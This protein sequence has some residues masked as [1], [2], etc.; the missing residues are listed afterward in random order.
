MTSI[1]A[2]IGDVLQR[3]GRVSLRLGDPPTPVPEPFATMLTTL[4]ANRANVNTAANPNSDWLFPDGRTG[5]PLSPGAF[6]QRLR[7]L[8]LPVA[9]TRTAARQQL[10]LQ[11]LAPVVAQ[12]LGYH[13]NTATKHR[14]AAGE[15]GTA[16]PPP[17]RA[18]M[19]RNPIEQA[20]PRGGEA[21]SDQLGA[22]LVSGGAALIV[23]LLGI[24]GAITAQLLATQRTSRNSLAMF[25][26]ER[27]ELVPPQPRPGRHLFTSGFRTT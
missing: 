4:A 17:G 14:T 3:H 9:Q 22:A 15:P 6:L 7:A 11:A 12:A 10:V 5:Q 23:A 2:S 25:D 24:A 27:A 19:A 20:T 8:G 1:G 21:V 26:R 13:H 16:T 18:R